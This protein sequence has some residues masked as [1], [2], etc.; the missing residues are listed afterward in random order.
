MAKS[1]NLYHSQAPMSMAAMG[2]GLAQAGANIADIGMKGSESMSKGI[3]GGVNTALNE[4]ANYKDTKSAV[5]ASEKA[6]ET[7]KS[8][9]PKELQFAFDSQLE[10]MGS[11]VATSLADRKAFWDQAKGF[12]GSATGH[13]FQMQKQKAELDARMAQQA[14]SDVEQ[15]KRLGRQ[16]DAQA[17]APYQRAEAESLYGSP[18]G[19]SNVFQPQSFGIAPPPSQ[20]SA[21]QEQFKNQFGRKGR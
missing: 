8:F 18:G 16:L 9:L 4:Y 20:P 3:M 15:N 5:T 21:L 14:A 10:S 7:I 13:A 19:A 17:M 6:Y 11:N 1:I 12:I 2:Q